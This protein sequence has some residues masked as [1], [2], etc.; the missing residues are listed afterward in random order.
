MT[1]SNICIYCWR[2]GSWILIKKTRRLTPALWTYI[3]HT[4]SGWTTWSE[5]LVH[6]HVLFFVFL[7]YVFVCVTVH[8]LLGNEDDSKCHVVVWRQPSQMYLSCRRCCHTPLHCL[9]KWC[10]NSSSNM[11]RF[12]PSSVTLLSL[13]LRLYKLSYHSFC[14]CSLKSLLFFLCS[15]SFTKMDSLTVKYIQ[16]LQHGIQC[17]M[18]IGLEVWPYPVLSQKNL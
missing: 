14:P 9:C 6:V 5:I 12:H 13:L 7:K 4:I 16:A 1:I 11:W 2:L 15:K 8:A 3:L 17:H 18:Y 10:P